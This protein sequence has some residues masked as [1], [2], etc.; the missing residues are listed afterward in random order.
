MQGKKRFRIIFSKELNCCGVR[1]P[2]E[3]MPVYEFQNGQTWVMDRGKIQ[4][5][6]S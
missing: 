2:F 5:R 4:K 3:Y 6:I 1:N